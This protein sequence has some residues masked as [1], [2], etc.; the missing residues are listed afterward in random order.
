[1][2]N[3][4]F[5]LIISDCGKID[6]LSAVLL[7]GEPGTGKTRFSK[8][9]A[10]K[11]GAKYL[12]YQCH[13]GTGKEEL[14][15]DLDIKGVIEYLG[16]RNFNPFPFPFPTMY[17]GSGGEGVSFIKKGLLYQAVEQSHKSRVVLTLDEIDKARPSLDGFLLDF[18]QNGRVSDPHLGVAIADSRNLIVVATSN[19][20]RLLSEPLYRR[21]RRIRLTI[22]PPEA[23]LKIVKEMVGETVFSKVGEK[24]VKFL[25]AIANAMR[26]QE[27]VIKK[28]TTPEISRL[29]FDFAEVEDKDMRVELLLTWFSPHR[30][31]WEILLKEFPVKYLRGML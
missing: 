19:E 20:E 5:N 29:V 14:L 16:R 17:S 25:I 21:F 10:E 23:E 31:D 12:F 11:W 13:Q 22:P 18:L 9:L 6:G 30:E 2:N 7:M 15:Y 3:Y 26:K 24:T 1:M 4:Y 28:V 27:C 8:I